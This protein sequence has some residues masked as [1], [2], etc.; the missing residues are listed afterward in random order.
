MICGDPAVLH[1]MIWSF[2]HL[3]EAVSSLPEACRLPDLGRASGSLVKDPR[4][5]NRAAR[6]S[7]HPLEVFRKWQIEC[8]IYLRPNR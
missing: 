3:E 7:N 8:D 1:S 4:P 2:P 5:W 6:R